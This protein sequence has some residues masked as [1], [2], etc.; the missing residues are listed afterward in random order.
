MRNHRSRANI[1]ALLVA[2]V[3]IAG[4][5]D[6]AATTSL[7]P[8]PS[9][10]PLITGSLTW[11]PC[12][13]DDRIVGGNAELLCA[14]LTVPRDYADA[15]AG[16][17]DLALALLPAADQASRLGSLL[18]NFGGPGDSGVNTLGSSGRD[19][20][21]AEIG[22]RFDLVT[23]DPRGT[24]R[25]APVD[26]LTDAEMDVWLNAP[27]I[28]SAPTTADWTKAKGDAT[29]FATS[30]A[31]K[32]GDLLRYIGS[33]ATARDMESIRAA[34]GAPK[35]DYLGFSYGTF[36]GAIYATLYPDS[37]GHLILDGAVDPK[38][39]DD[40]EWGEQGVSIQGAFDR[41]IAWCDANTSCPFGDG[42]TRKAFDALM[43]SLDA[44][45]LPLADGRSLN[46]PM[47]WTG[48]IL[49]LYN[50]SYWQYAVD[51]LAAAVDGDGSQLASLADYYNDRLADGSYGSNIMEAFLSITCI[52]HPGSADIAHYRT[53]Y[54]KYKT[55]APDFAA[56]Q[57]ASGLLCGAWKY[58]NADPLPP[59][60]NGAGAPPTLVVGTTGDPATPYAWSERLAKALS[61]SV[62]LTKVGE[63]HTAVGGGDLCIDASVIAFLVS[64]TL[65]AAGTRCE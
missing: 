4:C 31:E 24:G 23:W 5:G 52:D 20:V 42:A 17:I 2:L 54:E 46:A 11:S 21:P 53:I 25:S 57:A 35:L 56:G 22:N 1:A 60:I 6:G 62:L 37:V 55:K 47:A 33:T 58:K 64:S 29:K 45:P 12:P 19:V 63:G 49:T 7:T 3:V 13:A 51:G 41:L 61:G 15:T 10:T 26:C 43:T 36:I 9:G 18:L 39:T 50:R 38:P 27:G 28:D 44:K 16:T 65:P 14:T 40:S 32:S 8:T 59:T 30:C 48:V 34:M